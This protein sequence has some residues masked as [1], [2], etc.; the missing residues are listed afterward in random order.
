MYGA[1]AGEVGILR[2]QAATNQAV[3]AV[4]PSDNFV[5]EFLYYFLL[6][7]QKTLIATATGNAQPNI[8]Q[9]KIRAIR[10]PMIPQDEQ[11]RIVT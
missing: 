2:F 1:T 3:C 4:L 9:A 6:A 11:L 8:S 7:Q 5:P 10:I